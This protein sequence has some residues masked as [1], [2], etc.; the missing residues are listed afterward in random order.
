MNCTKCNMAVQ[1]DHTGT[2]VDE[3]GGDVCDLDRPHEVA[4]TIITVGME[5][6][7]IVS[8]TCPPNRWEIEFTH[9]VVGTPVKS[10]FP[11]T[12]RG[13]TVLP[14]DYHERV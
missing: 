4:Q 10:G 3:T 13:E 12:Y 5:D 14:H 8:V 1:P 11:V 9:L 6:R 2:L 7:T